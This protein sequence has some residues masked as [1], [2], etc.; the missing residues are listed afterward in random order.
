MI[1]NIRV[2]HL[3]E[4]HISRIDSLL[5]KAGY[6]ENLDYKFN[7]FSGKVELSIS[8]ETLYQELKAISKIN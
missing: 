6:K 2:T 4:K 8:N 7:Y 1:Y 5:K 3:K